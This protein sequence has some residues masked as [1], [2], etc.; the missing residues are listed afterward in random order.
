MNANSPHPD[1]PYEH[2]CEQ[3]KPEHVALIELAQKVNRLEHLHKGEC[4]VLADS[5]TKLEA[6]LWEA[7]NEI[8]MLVDAISKLEGALCLD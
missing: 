1:A 6:E 8:S 2:E 4:Q 3:H 7:R 5:I